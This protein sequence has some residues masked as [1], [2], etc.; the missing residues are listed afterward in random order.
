MFLRVDYEIINVKVWQNA[1][2][3]LE[4]HKKHEF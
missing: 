4:L 2:D 3:A 1:E